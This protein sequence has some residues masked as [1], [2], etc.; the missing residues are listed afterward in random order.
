[1]EPDLSKY[2]LEGDN[3]RYAG[4]SG[5]VVPVVTRAGEEVPERIVT[6]ETTFTPEQAAEA[7]PDRKY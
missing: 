5:L 3:T 1:M 7:L 6:E 4:P 2:V